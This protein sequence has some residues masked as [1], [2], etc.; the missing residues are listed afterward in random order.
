MFDQLI[1]RIALPPLRYEGRFTPPSPEGHSGLSRQFRR[2]QLGRRRGRSGSPGDVRH[3]RPTSPSRRR[4][5]PRRTTRRT[6]GERR[7]AGGRALAL[8]ENF[9]APYAVELA[10]FYLAARPAV[11]GAAVGLRGGCRPARPARSPGCTRT[12][13]CATLAPL[14]LPSED[15]RAGPRRPD[16]HRRRRRLHERHARLLRARLR[17]H[18]P[19]SSSGKPACRRAARRRR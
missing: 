11:P 9:G 7:A 2:L 10:P 13:P 17:R 3:A 8:N 1:C 12:A 16:H 19:A 5:L 18:A 14:P 15:G 4:L 6:A